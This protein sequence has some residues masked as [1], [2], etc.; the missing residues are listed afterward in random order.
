MPTDI[1]IKSIPKRTPKTPV[2]GDIAPPRFGDIDVKPPEKKPY[3][4]E[5]TDYV[6]IKWTIDVGEV[7]WDL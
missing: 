4:T 7:G 2:S 5:N 3:D 1:G 6:D